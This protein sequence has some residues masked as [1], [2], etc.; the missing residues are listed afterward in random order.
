LDPARNGANAYLVG[1]A[2]DLG[3]NPAA[4]LLSDSPLG[5]A[6]S[7]ARRIEELVMADPIFAEGVEFELRALRRKRGSAEKYQYA[8][9]K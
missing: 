3:G 7:G 4:A 8:G 9:K 2:G 5:A 6:L 1:T